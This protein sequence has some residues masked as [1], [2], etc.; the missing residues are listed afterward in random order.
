MISYEVTA[1]LAFVPV[2]IAAR[3]LRIFDIVISQERLWNIWIMFIP[4]IIVFLCAL[5]ECNRTPFDL[6]EA[7]SE[8]V[9]GFHV[10]YAAIGFTLIFLAEYSNILL[11]SHTM[12]LFFFGG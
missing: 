11:W 6:V 3:S 8:L 2:I 1:S 5:A 12:V 7:E 4:F 9:S 10:E